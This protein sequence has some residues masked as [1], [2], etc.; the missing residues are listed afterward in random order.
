M[1][2]ERHLVYLWGNGGYYVLA[3]QPDGCLIIPAG[4]KSWELFVRFAPHP[5][6]LEALNS[7]LEGAAS[8]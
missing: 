2:S 6:L 1:S 7:L 4:Q 3:R 5:L 8:R